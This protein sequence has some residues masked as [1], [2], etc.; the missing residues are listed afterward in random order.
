[1]NEQT[2]KKLA[3]IITANCTRQ[4]I[5]EENC[6]QGK[7]S[8]EDFNSFNKQMSDKVYTFLT[9]LLHKPADEYS[10]MIEELSKHYPETWAL[11]ELD[12]T[13]TQTVSQNHTSS[14]QTS[15]PH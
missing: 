10:V 12:T 2:V 9:Y 7:I 14:Q 8:Q 6:A 11:P 13:F 5:I 4:S 15:L 1:M 3:L